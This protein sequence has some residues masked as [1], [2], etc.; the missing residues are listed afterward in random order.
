MVRADPRTEMRIGKNGA[1]KFTG[2][3]MRQ[4]SEDGKTMTITWGGA[5]GK[6]NQIL[7]LDKQ[8]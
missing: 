6:V 3:I 5:D 1:G 4:V 2:T 8:Q 7:H